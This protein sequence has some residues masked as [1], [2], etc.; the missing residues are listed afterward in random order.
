MVP[1]AFTVEIPL[2][3]ESMLYVHEVSIRP[4]AWIIPQDLVKKQR[5]TMSLTVLC[6]TQPLE[7]HE[8]TPV[9]GH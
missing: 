2:F 5:K 1:E 7:E 6:Q 8:E 9:Q 4:S 3:S